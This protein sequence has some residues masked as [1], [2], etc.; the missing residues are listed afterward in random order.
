MHIYEHIYKR[1]YIGGS[2]QRAFVIVTYEQILLVIG[3]GT[4]AAVEH[5]YTY[6]CMYIGEEFVRLCVCDK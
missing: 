5:C 2:V 4:G 3:N 1:L 6:I